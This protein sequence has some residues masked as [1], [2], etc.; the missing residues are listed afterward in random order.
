[1]HQKE[2]ATAV[3]T[4]TSGQ[5]LVLHSHEHFE[6]E[7]P[8]KESSRI[9]KSIFFHLHKSHDN[10]NDECVHLKAIIEELIK[11]GRLTKYAVDDGQRHDLSRTKEHMK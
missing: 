10:N 8:M 2:S 3:R 5:I 11:K 9:E 6:E 7:N 4:M 1:M